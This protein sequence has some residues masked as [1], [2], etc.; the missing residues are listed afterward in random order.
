VT[1]SFGS[2]ERAYLYDDALGPRFLREVAAAPPVARDGGADEIFAALDW[3]RLRLQ[4]DQRIPDW[5][6]SAPQP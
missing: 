1:D 2:W 5:R 6:R 3:R 4:R